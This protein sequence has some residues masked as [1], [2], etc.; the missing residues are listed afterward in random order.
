MSTTVAGL[1]METKIETKE[2]TMKAFVMRRIGETAVADKPLPQVGPGDALIRTTAA[3]ICTSDVHTVAGAIGDRRDRTLGHEAVGV[4]EKLGSEVRGFTVGDRVVVGAITPCWRCENCQRG[5]PS[6]CGG[7]LGGW[8]FAN[9]KD[10][11]LAEYF[12]VND[13][14]ANIAPI[15]DDLPDEKA[16]YA[17]D[18]MSTGIAAAENAAIPTGGTVAVF[19]AGPVGLMAI[20]GAKL[21]G[22]GYVIAVEY[23]GKRQDFAR[24]Y[25]ADDVVG[26][27]RLDPVEEILKRTEGR[28]VDSAIEALGSPETFSNCVKV[29]RPGGTISNVGYHGHGE[30]V[31]IPRLEWGVGMAEKT[32]RTALCPGGR[33][34]MERML[35]LLRKRRI[36]PSPMTT[37]RFRF[38]EIERA[39]QMMARKEDG[40]IKPLIVF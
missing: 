36:D 18:M 14:E 24:Y 20:A 9:A 23:V 6:Q 35:R 28:G 29:T 26:I 7:P 3:L 39:F 1:E 13:A 16:V 19:G 32:I 12:H 33:V 4:I 38:S 2:R 31:P 37:H 25:G 11:S 34:R 21:L 40:I 27:P 22:A 17:C 10:G 30:A 8:K 15:P 5:F